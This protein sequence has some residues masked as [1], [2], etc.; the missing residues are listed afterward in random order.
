M[1]WRSRE[2]PVRG[3]NSPPEIEALIVARY[4]LAAR[5]LQHGLMLDAG[6]GLGYGDRVL[7]QA[8]FDVIAGDLSV[9]AVLEANEISPGPARLAFD[10]QELPFAAA[11]FSG[12]VCFE[13]IEHVLDPDRFCSELSRVLRLGGKA[14]ISTPPA[15]SPHEREDNPFHLRLYTS[16]E[17]QAQLAGHFSHVIIRAACAPFDLTRTASCHPMNRALSRLKRS[18]GIRRKLL[19]QAWWNAAFRR[20]SPGPEW[21]VRPDEFTVEDGESKNALS[22]VAICT[23]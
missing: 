23:K 20:V 9:E 17:L 14:V 16:E 3:M 6:C 22:L 15:D 2:R 18:L 13:V 10:A 4:Q 1:E 11:S 7:E 12:V 19:P 8:G 5:E 21:S